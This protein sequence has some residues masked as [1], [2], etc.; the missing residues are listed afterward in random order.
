MQNKYRVL[1][2]GVGFGQFYIKAIENMNEKFQIVGILSKGSELSQSYAKK[3]KIPIYTTLDDVNLNEIDLACV[4]I[5]STLIGGAGSDL[6]KQLLKNGVNVI[7]E[8]PVHLK[9]YIEFLKLSREN[10]C[11]YKLNTFYPNL[12]SVDTFLSLS[13]KLNK[14]SKIRFISAQCSVHVLFP[15]IDIL[16][17]ALGGLKPYEFRNIST[18]NIESPFEIIEGYIND[19]PICISV[20]NQMTAKNP[21]NYMLLMHKIMFITNSGNLTL[22]GTN[23]P[24]IWESC[25][26]KPHDKN[27][28][29]NLEESNEFSK[30]KTFEIAEDNEETYSSMMKLSWVNSISKSIIEFINCID[31]KKANIVEQQYLISAIETW[32][33]LS[34]ELG[35]SKIIQPYKKNAIKI[36][37]LKGG[38][39]E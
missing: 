27:G 1:V 23:G 21:D 14:L 17:R 15:L 19:I 2:C 29:F 28:K 18:Q 39:N 12:K 31:S 25:L 22:S 30:L 32:G 36:N 7:Q 20:Q 5:G 8:Q 26:D 24:I 9:E 33:E 16:G 3:Y 11:F 37:D 13:K 10:S 6:V 34:R 35:Q 4:V 38:K